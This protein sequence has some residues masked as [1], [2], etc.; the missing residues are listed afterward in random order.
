MIGA[1]IAGCCL[2]YALARRGVAAVLVDRGRVGRLGASAVGAAL[3]NPYRGRSGKPGPYDLEGL[4]S[5]WRLADELRA[6]GAQPG[7]RRSGVLRIASNARQA[8]AWQ[9]LPGMERQSELPEAYRA[10]AGAFLVKDGG[11]VDTSR[12]L[13]ALVSAVRATGA[14]VIEECEIERLE[15]LYGT[16]RAH[17]ERGAIAARSVALCLGAGSVPGAR[18]P[19]LDRIAGDQITLASDTPL[20]Y[21]VAGSVYLASTGNRV[22]LGGNH[23]DPGISDPHA[24]ELLRASAARMIP[25][26]AE[27]PIVDVWTGV[28]AKRPNNLPMVEELESDLWFLGAFGGRGFLTAP[29]LASRLADTLAGRERRAHE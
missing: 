22:L 14:E 9:E 1:G 12:L 24:P 18:V 6:G 13:S 15:R 19:Q 25:P 26:L 10:P 23:R 7:A 4:A 2:A 27:A 8:R 11:W 16:W 20:P 21:P 28:R 3:L 5:F 17:T 29:L